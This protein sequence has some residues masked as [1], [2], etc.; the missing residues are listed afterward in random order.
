MGKVRTKPPNPKAAA[1]T[2]A[3]KQRQ[4]EASLGHDVPPPA[5]AAD[6][7]QA[8]LTALRQEIASLRDEIRL[9]EQRLLAAIQKS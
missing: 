9:M 6:T 8:D 2:A 3:A 1:E 4:V 5:T 7:Q